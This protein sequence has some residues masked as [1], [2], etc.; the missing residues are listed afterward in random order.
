MIPFARAFHD[1]AGKLLPELIEI[2]GPCDRPIFIPRLGDA[3]REERG[4]FLDIRCRE[5]GRV[6]FEFIHGRKG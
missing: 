1:V 2:N 5:V 3:V 6:Q 4:E